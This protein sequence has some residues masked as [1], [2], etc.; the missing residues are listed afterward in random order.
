MVVPAW[1]NISVRPVSY[2]HLDVYKRQTPIYG[3]LHFH[4]SDRALR[5]DFDSIVKSEFK[6]AAA[7]SIRHLQAAL[8]QL[9]K[10]ARS[11]A[12]NGILSKLG[13]A[14]GI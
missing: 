9:D 7:F 8:S 1:S 11:A 2:T 10:E 5:K 14:L 6:E 4:G 13:K 12:A 3:Y